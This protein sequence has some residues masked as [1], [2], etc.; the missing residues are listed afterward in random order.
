[1]RTTGYGIALGKQ[2]FDIIEKFADYAFNK[3][4]TFGYGLITYQTAYLKAHFPVEYFS[5]LLTSVKHNL[6]KAA[7]YLADCRASGI[8]VLPPDI[9][10]SVS[11]FARCGAKTSLTMS[12]SRWAPGAILFGMSAV[13]N[14]GEGLVSQL[15]E[16]RDENGPYTT[17]YEFAERVPNLSYINELWSR[18]S[19]AGPSTVLSTCL[20]LVS[21]HESIIESTL[22]R[23]RERD[24][25]VLSLF[26]DW[27]GDDSAEIGRVERIEIPDV[28]YPKA[29]RLKAEKEMLGLYVSD[30]PLFG[31]ESALRRRAE[32]AIVDLSDM[33]DG[34]HVKVGGIITASA[35]KFTKKGDQ[36]AVFTL[37]DL[38]AAV[39][40]TVFPR[41]LAALQQSIVDD[42]IVAVKARL[43][44]RD[45]SRLGLI[46]MEI[47]TLTGLESGG[48]RPVRLRLPGGMPD[49]HVLEQLK[50]IIE[51]HQGDTPVEIEVAKGQVLRLGE[52]FQVD[53]SRAVGEL[54]V[55]F[56][57]EALPPDSFSR[58]P[59]F[60][61]EMAE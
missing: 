24:Q 5:A 18:S 20:G 28:E 30:H 37:E 14:V 53:P 46:A 42:R 50:A 44:R 16:E 54:R 25:G 45:E 40:V 7:V 59:E 17:F 4:H 36:M 31:V 35:K 51:E 52:G 6:D 1:M 49:R 11:D 48:S 13:R 23:R 34:S 61:P 43:D 32:H 12:I 15:V 2:L 33:E 21:V 9:N 29:E 22:S 39:E 41:T 3:S 47:E 27:N 55:A 10:R 57:H 38:D 60:A 26:G 56:G 19:T 58:L 8:K